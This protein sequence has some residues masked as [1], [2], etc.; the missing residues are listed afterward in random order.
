VNLPV[1]HQFASG[2]WVISGNR[3]YQN[4][5]GARLAKMNIPLPQQNEMSYVFN[6]RYEGGAEDGHGGFGLHLF[7][8]SPL[9]RASW[10]AGNSYLIWLNYDED[11]ADENIPA[12][13]SA[14]LYR[15]YSNSRMEL[16]HSIDL[17]NFATLLSPETL[18]RPITFKIVA[19]A[20]TGKITMYLPDVNNTAYIEFN[21]TENLPLKGNWLALRSNGMMLSFSN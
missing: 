10:G 1:D 12:G 15:S 11:P 5:T 8:D 13:L 20:N 21:V 7:V 4:D 19:D 14:L 6:A 9:G 2:D 17:N 16:E 18:S 3:L